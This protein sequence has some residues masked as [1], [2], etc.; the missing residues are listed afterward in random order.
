M[1]DNETAKKRGPEPI[2]F[3]RDQEAMAYGL[4][5]HGVSYEAIAKSL[6]VSIT[7]LKKHLGPTLDAAK[8]QCL[9][10]IAGSLYKAA[11]QAQDAGHGVAAAKYILGTQ[12]GWIEKQQTQITGADGGPVTINMNYVKPK[13]GD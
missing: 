7:T 12:G 3:S 6:N 13:D 2:R 10:R 4:V 5:L 1:A 11:L 9:G 8:G